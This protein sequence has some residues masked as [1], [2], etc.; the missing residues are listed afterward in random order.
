[1]VLDRHFNIVAVNNA[2]E[3]A[4]MRARDELIGRYLFD[5]FPNEEESGRRLRASFERVFRTGK[6]DSLAYIPY[7]IPKPADQGGGMEQRFWTAVHTPLQDEQGRVAHLLQNTVD[8]TEIVRLRQAVNLPF[9]FRETH[10][11]ERAREAERQRSTLMAEGE[12][13]R[14]LFQQAPG[15]FAVVSGPEHVFT[16]AND[17]YLRVI[18]GRNVL[19][20]KVRDALPEIEGQGFFELLDGVYRTG[21]PARGEAVRVMVQPEEGGE[22]RETFLDFSYD[23]IR[24][25]EDTII[26]VFVQGMDRTESVRAH[27]QQRLLLDELNHRVKNTLSA[28]QSIAAQTMRSAR[29]LKSANKDLE[30]RIVAL[31]KAHNLLSAKEWTDAELANV[32]D[33]E[34]SAYDQ[35]RI[36]TG[37]SK[38][39]LDPKTAIALAL[40]LHELTTNA[41]KYGALSSSQ[42]HLSVTWQALPDRTLSLAWMERTDNP[43]APP[44]RHGFGSR[45][46]ER[47]I[48]GELGGTY[49]NRYAREGFSCRI[50][51]PLRT[52]ELN[53][54][55]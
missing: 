44:E 54:C 29:D 52:R 32:V 20:M 37:G 38:V 12:D 23:A 2:Y 8:V 53:E 51:V 18:G 9:R 36:E 19:G 49:E 55:H 30:A 22:L 28:V 33:Q 7:D 16:F 26:G 6:P 47:V 17:S 45:M 13:F 27:R 39:A 10:L 48:S 11:L 15:F 46:I 3:R 50:S 31:S 25:D 1:M 5:V 42:G 34:L 35:S 40:V 43:V 24:D 41:A 21:T 14:R 4:T